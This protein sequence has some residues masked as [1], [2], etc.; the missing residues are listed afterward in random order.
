MG[1]L[2]CEGK[3]GKGE[4]GKSNLGFERQKRQRDKRSETVFGERRKK[5]KVQV[6][7]SSFSYCVSEI[8]FKTRWSH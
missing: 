8:V 4:L 3:N 2:N 1:R 6:T 7:S 5:F